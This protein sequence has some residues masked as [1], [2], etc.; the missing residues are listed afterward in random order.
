MPYPHPLN[1]AGSTLPIRRSG[2]ARVD[3]G[4]TF[5]H[6]WRTDLP[7]KAPMADVAA[8]QFGVTFAHL[9]GAT[10]ARDAR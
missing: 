2:A 8:S 7:D 4:V 1:N 9:W 10:G 5:A 3:L 6:L